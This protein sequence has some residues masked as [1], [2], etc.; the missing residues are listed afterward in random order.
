MELVVEERKN[1]AYQ[2]VEDFAQRLDQK[3]MNKRQF[4]Q[5]ASAGAFDTL[6]SNRAQMV[7][8]AEIILRYAQSLAEERESGQVSL[9]GGDQPGSGLGLPDLPQTSS[10]DSLEQLSHEFSAVGFYLSA[11]PLDSRQQQFEK[12]K[13]VSTA[14]VEADMV[15]KTASRYHMAG[16][17]LKKQEKMSQRGSKYAFLQLSDPTGIFEVM[18]FSE[19]LHASREYLEPGTPLLLTVEAEQREDQVRFTTQKIAPLE[20]ALEGKIQEVQI[21]MSAGK[22]AEKIKEFLDGEGQGRTKIILNLRVDQNRIAKIELPGKWSFSAQARNAVR[23]EE[24]VL[25]ISEA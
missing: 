6:N 3:H 24:G 15:N 25:E 20:E 11:H 8:G 12:L 18:L 9:F 2:S 10:W 14:D 4:E 5:L 22:P 21:S 23:A 17:L 13:I 1:G 16:V 19:I 7:G